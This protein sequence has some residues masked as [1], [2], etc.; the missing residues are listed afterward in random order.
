[1][2]GNIRTLG[3]RAAILGSLVVTTWIAVR[4]IA[5]SGPVLDDPP[6]AARAELRDDGLADA[7]HRLAAAART[8]HA[9]VASR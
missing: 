3:S 1:M 4:A 6:L 5:G 8:G 2:S 7:I 9:T